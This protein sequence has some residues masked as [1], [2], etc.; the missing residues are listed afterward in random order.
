MYYIR[1]LRFEYLGSVMELFVIV[2]GIFFRY[3]VKFLCKLFYLCLWYI[4]FLNGSCFA[5]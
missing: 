3:Y 5:V 4:D 1:E 2:V